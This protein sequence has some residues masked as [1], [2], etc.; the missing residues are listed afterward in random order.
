MVF[1]AVCL[2]AMLSPVSGDPLWVGTYDGPYDDDE[3]HA[4]GVDDSG[5]VVVSGRSGRSEDD[6]EFVTIKYHPDGDTVW[7]RRFNPGAGLDGATALAVDR[8]GNVVVTGY[9]GG[10]T[11]QYGDWVTIRY[12]AAGESLWATVHDE[13]DEDRASS[14]VVDS[15]GSSYVTGR[16]GWP[17]DLDYVVVKYG[18]NGSAVWIF[19]FNSGY[20]DGANAVALDKQ[21]YA[22]V[23]GYTS[24]GGKDFALLTWKLG[25]GGDS[26]W[27]NLYTG[28]AGCDMQ[29]LAVAADGQG[30]AVVAGRSYDTL[31]LSDYLT[32]KYGP[33]GD[34][35]WTRRYNGPGNRSD[36]VAGLAV[37]GAGNVYV[38]GT[39]DVDAQGHYNYATVKYS[40]EGEQR[41][42]AR[43]VGPEG[44]DQA[45]AI[46]LDADASVYVTGK[47]VDSTGGSDAVTVK[48]DSA[49]NQRWVERYDRPSTFDEGCVI[50]LSQQGD[51]FV[52]G[53][54]DDDSTGIDYL[55]LAYA[56]VSAV[57]EKQKVEVRTPNAGPTIVRGVLWLGTD[58]GHDP[59]RQTIRSCPAS[60][61][62][63]AG[64]KVIGL[65]V[66]AND[67]SH[68]APGVYFM[69]EQSKLN[70]HAQSVRTVV[71][72]K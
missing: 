26:V 52:G 63:A 45:Y 19:R 29:G 28:P 47:S 21:G 5:N 3:V 18:L 33:R 50:A 43:Y 12:T 66:G 11:S 41:W 69:W 13:G 38:T 25:L 4:I 31:T 59:N 61:L 44:W 36:E 23:T 8:S 64:R 49:G 68:L 15:A 51:V 10:P 27:A 72:I 57:A 24:S 53:R 2:L 40:P 34:T 54:T 67:I 56:A 62:D 30:N 60:L 39:S 37:D 46:A 9:L 70:H 7:L 22:Y 55:T 42:V 65:H 16:A 20:N 35:L 17:N 71:L 6:D 48:Y 1:A 58:L 32:V 14:V